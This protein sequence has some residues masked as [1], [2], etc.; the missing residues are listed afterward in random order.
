LLLSHR[1]KTS[2]NGIQKG[3]CHLQPPFLCLVP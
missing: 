1:T 2:G 3:G